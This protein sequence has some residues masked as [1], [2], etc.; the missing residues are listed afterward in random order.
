MKLLVRIFLGCLLFLSGCS[1]RIPS[2]SG[3]EIP[4][5]PLIKAVQDVEDLPLFEK[6][7]WVPQEW[8]TIFNDD[9]LTDLINRALSNNPSLQ[10]AKAKVYSALYRSD[11]QRSYLYPN[12]YN[13]VDVQREKLSK[14]SLIPAQASPPPVG[15]IPPVAVPIPFYFTQ[16]DFNFFLTYDFDLWEKRRNTYRAALGELQA[17]LADRIFTELTVSISLAQSYF[18][19][20]TD[21]YRKELTE[22]LVQIRENN[23]NLIKNRITHNLDS[24][25]NLYQTED[26]LTAARQTL[27]QRV[28]S[29][30][31][32]EL[33]VQSY[34]GGEFDTEIEYI[35]IP[36]KAL[37]KVPLPNVLPLHLIAHRPDIISQLWMLESAGRQ[38]KIAQAGFYPDFNLTTLLGFQTIH[39]KKLFEARSSV[40]DFEPAYTLP[41]FDGGLL[42]ANLRGSE[43]NYD[44]AIFEYNQRVINAV[45]EVLDALVIVKQSY[46]RLQ[47][48]RQDADIQRKALDLVKQRIKNNLSSLIDIHLSEETYITALDNEAVALNNTFSAILNLIKALGG[49]YDIC[50]ENAS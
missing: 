30:L 1:N 11:V 6:T 17:S 18:Q 37:P 42:T 49:G 28:Q 29:A 8:W 48:A 27:S 39:F 10:S 2:A 21:R 9:Q 38:I 23:L 25:L 43:V 3:I 4:D 5:A 32:D 20:Q 36:N 24:N 22:R 14:T 50:E 26:L 40:Y 12:V 41:I 34:I 46:I 35:S 13:E 33:Q 15:V 31:H 47:E 7:E 16:Y 19:L 45:Q 44:L